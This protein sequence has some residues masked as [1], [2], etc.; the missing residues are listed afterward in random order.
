MW[1]GGFI[2]LIAGFV[3]FGIAAESESLLMLTVGLIVLLFSSAVL[4]AARIWELV[5]GIRILAGN[6]NVDGKGNPLVQ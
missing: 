5:D 3:L 4:L 6:L 2:F 1:I